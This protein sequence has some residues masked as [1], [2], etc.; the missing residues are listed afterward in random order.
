MWLSLIALDEIKVGMMNLRVF[1]CIL[2]V[3]LTTFKV[4]ADPMQDRVF[5]KYRNCIKD[6]E[7]PLYDDLKN[8]RHGLD[9]KNI[10]RKWVA[11][12]IPEKDID[13]AYDSLNQG[14]LKKIEKLIKNLEKQTKAP[15]VAKFLG[16]IEQT[17]MDSEVMSCRNLVEPISQQ[18]TLVLTESIEIQHELK[19]I[20]GLMKLNQDYGVNKQKLASQ[21]DELRNLRN[22]VTEKLGFGENDE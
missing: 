3:A 15:T 14:N 7:W 19:T 12:V 20:Y 17:L 13:E 6:L 4:N 1:I 16:Y 10:L 5:S 18:L 9:R 8:I 21:L 2:F 22:N 11:V